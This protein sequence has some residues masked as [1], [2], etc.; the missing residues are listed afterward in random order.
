M[1]YVVH[2]K[3]IKSPKGGVTGTPGPPPWLRPWSQVVDCLM[4]V[5]KDTHELIIA[6]Y[7]TTS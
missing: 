4:Q 7:E 5:N 6:E 2:L 1:L 3:N